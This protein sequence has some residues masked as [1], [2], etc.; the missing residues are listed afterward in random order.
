MPSKLP[1]RRHS[2]FFG[3]IWLAPDAAHNRRAQQSMAAWLVVVDRRLT[4]S[5][6]FTAI[7][8]RY[9]VRYLT[10]KGTGSELYNGTVYEYR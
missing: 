3:E 6:S 1:V 2:L 4:E 8:H 7:S 10:W 5:C 9:L